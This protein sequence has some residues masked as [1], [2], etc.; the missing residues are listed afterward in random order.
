MRTTDGTVRNNTLV[1]KHTTVLC[2][3][4][5]GYGWNEVVA[6][7]HGGVRRASCLLCS[8][9]GTMGEEDADLWQKRVAKR[10][11]AE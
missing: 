9:L 4:C 11:S 8:G 10:G 2:P 6:N 3:R 7:T 5:D 1:R